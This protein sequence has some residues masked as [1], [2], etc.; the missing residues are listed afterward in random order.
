LEYLIIQKKKYYFFHFKDAIR[1]EYAPIIEPIE[2]GLDE[3]YAQLERQHADFAIHIQ[4][5]I[6]QIQQQ[7]LQ[8]HQVQQQTPPPPPPPPPHLMNN[9]FGI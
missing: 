2:A 6:S 4:T 5:Q 1:T 7:I 8:F 3:K 9:S